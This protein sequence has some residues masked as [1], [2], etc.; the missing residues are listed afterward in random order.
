MN[1]THNHFPKNTVNPKLLHHQITIY[2]VGLYQTITK[3]ISIYIYRETETETERARLI[4]LI[5]WRISLPFMMETFPERVAEISIEIWNIHKLWRESWLELE[6]GEDRRAYIEVDWLL[7]T[8][9]AGDF[10]A[11]LLFFK[12]IKKIKWKRRVLPTTFLLFQTFLL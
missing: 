12:K 11:T 2:S 10:K 3:T 7:N 4:T 1:Q 8:W 9:Q 5:F 6:E